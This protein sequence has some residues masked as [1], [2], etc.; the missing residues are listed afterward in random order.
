MQKWNLGAAKS[1]WCHLPTILLP[2]FTSVPSKSQLMEENE[3]VWTSWSKLIYLLNILIKRWVNNCSWSCQKGWQQVSLCI[4][5]RWHGRG[6][7]GCG[8]P[9][10]W[11][12]RCSCHVLSVGR[13]HSISSCPRVWPEPRDRE[14][15]GRRHPP[16]ACCY[17]EKRGQNRAE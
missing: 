6:S 11:P 8:P 14:I 1:S 5:G 10:T 12:S 7:Q 9:P 16:R 17:L 15:L 2:E 13:S 4:M 3:N